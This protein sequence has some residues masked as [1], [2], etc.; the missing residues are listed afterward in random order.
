MVRCGVRY[1][2]YVVNSTGCKI[3][4]LALNTGMVT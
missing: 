4:Y 3:N 2:T 1:K